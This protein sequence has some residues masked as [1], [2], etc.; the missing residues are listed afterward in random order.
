MVMA[1]FLLTLVVAVIAFWPARWTS[2]LN[3]LQKTR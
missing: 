2:A 1:L 3:R